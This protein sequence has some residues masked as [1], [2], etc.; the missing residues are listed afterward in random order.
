MTF[1]SD[2]P[3]ARTTQDKAWTV[4]RA[5]CSQTVR[6]VD[7][8]KVTGNSTNYSLNLLA[9]AVREKRLKDF[10]TVHE[11]ANTLDD[12]APHAQRYLD[13]LAAL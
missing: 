12:F 5:F 10:S 2:K 6:L 3:K 7:L 11:E 1:D 9:W 4:Y 8:D 13:E